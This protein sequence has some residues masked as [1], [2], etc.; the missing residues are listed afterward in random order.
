MKIAVNFIE[1][2]VLKAVATTE[3]NLLRNATLEDDYTEN[4][5]MKDTSTVLVLID[6]LDKEVM[7]GM[8][9]RE[10]ELTEEEAK[11]L[12]GGIYTDINGLDYEFEKEEI[13]VYKRL[14]K[15]F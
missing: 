8:G 2:A 7:K 10:V 11:V 3:L 14:C 5:L 4:D 1:I 15:K 13:T 12:K 6:K 9:T